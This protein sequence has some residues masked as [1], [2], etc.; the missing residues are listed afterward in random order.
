MLR[1]WDFFKAIKK[2]RDAERAVIDSQHGIIMR[3]VAVVILW[4]V[5]KAQRE[6]MDGLREYRRQVVE[7]RKAG[8]VLERSMRKLM[9]LKGKTL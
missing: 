8:L 6:N 3:F 2:E 7:M 9:K 1:R 5:G 4:R